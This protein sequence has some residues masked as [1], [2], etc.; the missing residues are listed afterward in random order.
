M[1]RQQQ[2]L[3]RQLQDLQRRGRQQRRTRLSTAG[4][5]PPRRPSCLEERTGPWPDHPPAPVGGAAV[6]AKAP[7]RR[8]SPKLGARPAEVLCPQPP[9][10]SPWAAGDPLRGE[11]PAGALAWP[12][13]H[14]RPRDRRCPRPRQTGQGGGAPPPDS[15]GGCKYQGRSQH[16][17]QQQRG[18][19]G[20]LGAHSAPDPSPSAGGAGGSKAGGGGGGGGDL[21]HSP[22]N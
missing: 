18:G 21:R 1:E 5:P 20:G 15:G 14:R 11:P 9:R 17:R 3:Q 22:G 7:R 2:D 10:R 19:G 8:P 13:T 6:L 4:R 16:L 12:R